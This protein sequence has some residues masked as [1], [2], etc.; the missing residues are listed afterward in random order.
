MMTARRKAEAYAL[1]VKYLGE[2]RARRLKRQHPCRWPVVAM[3]EVKRVIEAELRRRE[4]MR[5]QEATP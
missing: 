4:A 3:D 2:R 5:A 1:A